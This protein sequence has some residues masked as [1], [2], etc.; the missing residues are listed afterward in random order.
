MASLALNKDEL[1]SELT[2][3]VKRLTS[4]LSKER[5]KA[6]FLTNE[7]SALKASRVALVGVNYLYKTINILKH[8]KSYKLLF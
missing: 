3:E 7:I 8:L 4:E 1:I 6:K 5:E 2:L